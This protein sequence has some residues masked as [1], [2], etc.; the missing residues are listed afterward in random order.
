M[1][2]TKN[3]YLSQSDHQKLTGILTAMKRKKKV[4]SPHLRTLREELADAIIISGDE[5][6]RE[7]AGMGSTV[8]YHN[9]LTGRTE[10]AK[11]VFPAEANV[12]QGKVSVL[13]PLG[14]ALI[15]ESADTEVTC[16]GPDSSW[17]L[18]ILNVEHV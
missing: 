11:L 18:Q 6:P 2:T 17:K 15:G 8:Q 1:T 12:D 3:I 16:Q 9:P 5:L 14:A 4:L 10:F 13:A 7:I